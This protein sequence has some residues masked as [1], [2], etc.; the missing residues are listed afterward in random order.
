MSAGEGTSPQPATAAAA[1]PVKWP[2][3]KQGKPDEIWPAYFQEHRPPPVRVQGL[4]I[5]MHTAGAHE[6]VISAIESALINGQS[7]PWMYEVLALSMEL[8]G[9]PRAQ[10]ERV[11][12]S[13]NDFGSANFASMMYSAAYL[14]RFD[15]REAALR[16]YRE[17][18]ELEPERPEPYVLGL[19]HAQHVRDAQAVSWAA[20]GILAYAW[21]RD[22]AALH[23][24]AENAALE[25]EQW[26]RKA[27]HAAEADAIRDSLANARRRDLIVRLN[28]SGEGDL[29]LLVEEPGG[30]VCSFKDPE[31][32]SGGVLTHDGY[33]PMP[34]NCY[35][36]Y[37]CAFG[38]PGDYHLRVRRAWGKIVG[39]RATLTI[40]RNAGGADE[41][42]ETRTVTLAHDEA[43][44]DATLATGR[45]TGPRQ[46]TT[47][48]ISTRVDERRFARRRVNDPNVRAAALS[49]FEESRLDAA[50]RAGAVGF[51]PII[52]VIPEGAQS[53][54]GAV[55]SADR[56]YVRL[57]MAPLFSNVIDVIPFSFVGP[58]P[59]SG[60]GR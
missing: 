4:I 42:T 7:Q 40:I 33:G 59:G 18:S 32:A 44:V 53:T 57:S 43:V 3:W 48:D 54:A 16:L 58:A 13:L 22:Y 10:I 8:A 14:S 27:G 52:E 17:A 30:A 15:R 12:L 35:E 45:R 2:D 24:D 38:P 51:Q 6:H 25:A 50:R 23:H 21:T 20:N 56:R 60:T 19:N 31:T 37:V 9:R 26:E 5:Q 46:V 49:D 47:L 11:V 36:E 39:D 55:V 29:D 28:W 1:E 34:A 41:Q